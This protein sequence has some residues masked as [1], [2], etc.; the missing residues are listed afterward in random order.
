MW[1]DLV[2]KSARIKSGRRQWALIW[3]NVKAHTVR[4]VREV[5]EQAG[6]CIFELPVNM[7]DILQPVDIVP[8]GPLKSR[9]RSARVDKLY[10]YFQDWRALAI[11][12]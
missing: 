2:M 3:D 4:S 7:T 10:S 12:R 8:N 6:I 5:F 9:I 11:H 1:C